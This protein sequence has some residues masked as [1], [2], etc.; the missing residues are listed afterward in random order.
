MNFL[1][2]AMMRKRSSGILNQMHAEYISAQQLGLSYD[3]KIFTEDE[4]IPKKYQDILKIYKPKNK[5]KI[6]RWI[7]FRKAYYTWLL[8]QQSSLDCFIL[9]HSLYDPFQ[10]YFI[11]FANIPVFLV[12]HTKEVEELKSFGIKGRV[13]SLIE[14]IFG[15]RSLRVCTGIVGV[16]NE[17]IEYEKKRANLINKPSVL[18][19]NGVLISGAIPLD[20]RDRKLIEIMFV[21]SFFYDWHGLDV[22]IKSI[23]ASNRDDFKLHLIGEL[24][25]SDLKLINEDQRFIVHGLLDVKEISKISECCTLALGSFALNR[26]NIV[27]GSTLKVREYLSLGLPVY[28]GHQDVFPS[29]FIFYKY[30]DVNIDA[31][32]KYAIEMMNYSKND[33][34]DQSS[35][36]ISK[37]IILNILM[38]DNF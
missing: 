8:S 18:Y 13:L 30:G 25:K 21:A 22:L 15:E 20:R 26:K 19:S 37:K 36:H 33:I 24:S 5:N 27:E 28:S 32:L 29:D 34:Y 7:E 31:I 3:V 6:A 1:H 38:V 16:T 17:L 35:S 12:H 11:K 2:T 23:K 10:Y 4:N 14:K 9:R